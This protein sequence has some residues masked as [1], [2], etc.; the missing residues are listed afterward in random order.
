[1]SLEDI[2]KYKYFLLL[3]NFNKLYYEDVLNNIRLSENEI[4]IIDE[5]IKKLFNNINNNIDIFI[6]LL[7]NLVGY[8]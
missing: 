5:K 7:L 2:K 6:T 1:M 8:I 3:L 4:I